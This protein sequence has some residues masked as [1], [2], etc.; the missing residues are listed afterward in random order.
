MLGL[1]TSI[2]FVLVWNCP[3]PFGLDSFWFLCVVGTLTFAV[4]LLFGGR[5][6]NRKPVKPPAKEIPLEGFLGGVTQDRRAA[7]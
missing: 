4:A 5:L 6:F 1:I 7:P 3:M 2:R